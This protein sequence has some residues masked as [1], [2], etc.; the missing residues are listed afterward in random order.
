M[1]T[2]RRVPASRATV[3]LALVAAGAFAAGCGDGSSSHPSAPASTPVTAPHVTPP[4]PSPSTGPRVV[5]MPTYDGSGE[6]VHP[7]AVTTPAGWSLMT[8]HVVATPYPGGSPRFENPSYYDVMTP[9]MW[10]P[11]QGGVNPLATPTTRSYLSD[12]DAVYDP[13]AHGLLVYYREVT[14]M[15]TIYVIRSADGAHWDTPVS[16]LSV[17][18]HLAISPAVV[19]RG[20]GDWLMWTVNAGA[21]GCS[22]ASTTVEVRHSADGL[23]WGPPTP[24][25]IAS[26]GEYPWHIEVEWIPSR[27]EYWAVFNTKKGGTCMTR[28][29][30]F[31]TSPDGVTWKVF[32]Y[33]LLRAGAIPAFSDVVYRSSVEYDAASDQVTLLYSGASATDGVYT[34]KVASEQLTLNAL[35]SRI[36]TAPPAKSMTSASRNTM[37]SPRRRVP[38]LTNETAP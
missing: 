24:V 11:T 18:N 36:T 7:D 13:D 8:D 12:P 23:A 38:E 32:P 9:S 19:R 28:I 3:A 1:R 10:L 21:D 33:P 35:M 20:P 14:D 34:W 4:D 17:P 37:R 15:N 16:V 26:D 5:S 27:H 31:A 22:A 29:L 30:R 6:V 2:L 25:Q